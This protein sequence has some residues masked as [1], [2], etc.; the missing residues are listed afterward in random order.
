ML[1]GGPATVRNLW[2]A[3]WWLEAIER[4]LKQKRACRTLK[5]RRVATRSASARVLIARF[6]ALRPVSLSHTLRVMPTPASP[7]AT[8]IVQK[9]VS[10]HQHITITHIYIVHSPPITI[11][12]YLP[13]EKASRPVSLMRT[14]S[15]AYLLCEM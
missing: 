7:P 6:A 1:S 5:S 9:P 12:L 10:H 2:R 3:T 4:F 11:L 8:I 15:S 14:A 13:A